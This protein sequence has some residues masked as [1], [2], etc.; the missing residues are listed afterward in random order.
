MAHE[1][2]NDASD[3]NPADILD[4]QPPSEMNRPDALQIGVACMAV[5]V[6]VALVVA[7]LPFVV[8]AI[9]HPAPAVDRV[10]LACLSVVNDVAAFYFFRLAVRIFWGQD[11]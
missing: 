2:S 4:Y 5:L 8:V 3:D 10:L 6:G 9:E 7:G 1:C 11:S